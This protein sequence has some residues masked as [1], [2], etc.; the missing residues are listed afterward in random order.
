MNKIQKQQN[1]KK[2]IENLSK[3]FK[4]EKDPERFLNYYLSLDVKE[5][6]L[7]KIDD[8]LLITIFD[9][10]TDNIF[11]HYTYEIGKTFELN[12]EEDKKGMRMFRIILELLEFVDYN[13][14]IDW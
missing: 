14:P 9:I 8:E 3:Y 1:K 11:E 5:V 13:Q 6:K 7:I 12:I 10:N 4:N 2:C